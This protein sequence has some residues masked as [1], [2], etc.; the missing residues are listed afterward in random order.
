[1]T[2][3]IAYLSPLPPKNTENLAR[4][5]SESYDFGRTYASRKHARWLF[6][7]TTV[8]LWNLK[9]YAQGTE[10]GLFDLTCTSAVIKFHLSIP[11]HVHWLQVACANHQHI[12]WPRMQRTYI[13]LTSCVHQLLVVRKQDFEK[14]L[15]WKQSQSG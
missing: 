10:R 1:M 12:D 2:A 7:I 6:T 3:G 9:T 8:S 14:K 11:L 13:T 4:H 15:L 5:A